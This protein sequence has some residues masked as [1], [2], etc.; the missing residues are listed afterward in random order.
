MTGLTRLYDFRLQVAGGAAPF[1][2]GDPLDIL[3]NA[4][5]NLG[6]ELE[7]RKQPVE[8][9]VVDHAERPSPN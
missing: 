8:V 3:P 1:G 7:S 4:L 2:A 5:E 6:L 9:S